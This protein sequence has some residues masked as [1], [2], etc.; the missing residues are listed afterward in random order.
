MNRQRH[1]AG[2][3][4]EP[5]DTAGHPTLAACHEDRDQ[6]EAGQHEET[7]SRPGCP[8]AAPRCVA[9]PD[10][11]DDGGAG[12]RKHGKAREQPALRAPRPEM[13][14]AIQGAESP[15]VEPRQEIHAEPLGERLGTT[16]AERLVDDPVGREKGRERQGQGDKAKRAPAHQAP[17][18]RVGPEERAPQSDGEQE[19]AGR[20]RVVERREGLAP[21]REH[22]DEQVA[23]ARFLEEAEVRPE[24]HGQEEAHL[25]DGRVQMLEAVGEV[26]E[27]DA[28]E[29]ARGGAA[30]EGP[31]Q[32]G[33][34]EPAQRQGH[35]DHGVGGEERIAR[36][37]HDGHRHDAGHEHGLPVG[38][39]IRV[40][41][42]ERRVEE[43]PGRVE[44][45]V[46]R[47]ADQGG[48]ARMVADARQEQQAGAQRKGE[49]V[50]DGG[51]AEEEDRQDQT[52]P[53]HGPGPAIVGE[54]QAV[55]W[56]DVVVLAPAR[57][58]YSPTVA[59]R[60]RRI[61]DRHERARRASWRAAGPSRGRYNGRSSDGAAGAARE[62]EWRS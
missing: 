34:R 35:E 4:P 13:V 29:H 14:R 39:G 11:Q 19:E 17:G 36:R 56:P 55:G 57:G 61:P 60:D 58:L 38:L 30:R 20:E 21:E 54:H 52:A 10:R 22:E 18:E 41:V 25:D 53:C 16:Q 37:R 42:E 59:S 23:P 28:R 12:Q 31:G 43:M 7:H 8:A 40:G 26:G 33:R 27:D 62:A 48:L 51:G 50:D 32:A 24:D 15:R 46:S 1:V 45:L 44:E 9:R 49:G 47:P 5:G 2:P 3:E 6:T